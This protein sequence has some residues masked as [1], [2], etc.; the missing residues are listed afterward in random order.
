MATQAKVR[1]LSTNEQAGNGGF[2][3]E[4]TFGVGRDNLLSET[5]ADAD[6]TF[7]LFKT[8]AGDVIVKWAL[9][10]DPAFSDASDAA[11]NSVAFSFGDEDSGSRF[12]SAVQTNV[13]GTEV[14]S[15]YGNTAYVYAAV[16]QVNVLI[17]SMTA[18]SLSDLDAGK[19]VL[20]FELTRLD[21][22]TKAG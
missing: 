7:N 22:L 6:M 11:F 15:T 2:T 9:K 16:K 18:K 12:L 5:T 13:N 8:R 14:I 19:A 20:L 17:E 10:L 21:T 4:V 3:H 1:P